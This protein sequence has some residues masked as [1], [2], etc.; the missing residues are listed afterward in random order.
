M[1]V[2]IIIRTYNE[3]RW[4]VEVLEAIAGQ[5]SDVLHETIIVDSGSTDDTLIIAERHGCR[6]EHISK[7]E[8]TFG[9]SLNVGCAAARG[10]V[11]VFLSGH[12]IPAVH[13]WLERLIEPV[14]NGTVAYS[15]GRQMGK[16]GVSR[17]SEQMLFEKYFPD[18]SQ[19]PQE[20]FFCNNANAA[21]AAGVWRDHPFDEEVTGL[22]DIALAKNLVAN[23]MAIGYVAEAPVIHIHEETWAQVKNRYEREAIAMQLIMPDIYFGFFDFLWFTAAGIGLDI[24]DALRR[25]E[26]PGMGRIAVWPEIALFR[27]HQYWGTYRGSTASLRLSK[28]QK[29][30]YYYPR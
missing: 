26:L 16:E 20:G 24:K 15:Y 9:R 19:L 28:L 18:Q 4:L 5:T 23:E 3:S 11:L 21:L 1:D 25:D 30:K 6:V 14:V 17:F 8:F 10:N 7:P 29:Q 2:S 12:C 22:E 13:D 27:Y